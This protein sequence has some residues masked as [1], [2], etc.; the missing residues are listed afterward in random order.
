MGNVQ[1]QFNIEIIKLPH[2]GR[3]NIVGN[4]DA[5]KAR[6]CLAYFFM[7]ALILTDKNF[8]AFKS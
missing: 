5:K 6:K 2:H 1:L 4:L 8:V 3:F 7:F